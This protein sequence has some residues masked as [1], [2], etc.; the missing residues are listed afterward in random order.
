MTSSC[1]G[2]SDINAVTVNQIPRYMY[3]YILIFICTYGYSNHNWRFLLYTP[4][5]LIMNIEFENHCMDFIYF[6]YHTGAN[7]RNYHAKS[8]YLII[9]LFGIPPILYGGYQI[10]RIFT[11]FSAVSWLSDIGL[12]RKPLS[13]HS[14]DGLVNSRGLCKCRRKS[15]SNSKRTVH[16]PQSTIDRD[17]FVFARC[18]W[19]TTLQCNIQLS[20]KMYYL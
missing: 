16:S 10:G 13:N 1:L 20:Y 3:W 6:V 2:L 17:H 18:Q 12:T 8:R 15:R 7:I 9:W 5:N 11:Y 19:A 14:I 4:Y